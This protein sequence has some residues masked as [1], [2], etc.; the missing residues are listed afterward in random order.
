MKDVGKSRTSETGSWVVMQMVAQP[1]LSAAAGASRPAA[2]HPG[3]PTWV[4]CEK[5]FHAYMRLAK[6][7]W[8]WQPLCSTR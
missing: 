6:E 8:E 5:H 2:F 1:V 3:R 7:A 4:V